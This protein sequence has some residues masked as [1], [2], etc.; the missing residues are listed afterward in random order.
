MNN[1]L[2]F[3]LFLC[4][5]S[6]ILL[7]G[8]RDLGCKTNMFAIKKESDNTTW[9][10][11]YHPELCDIQIP[12]V[13]VSADLDQIL[14]HP[15]DQYKRDRDKISGINRF[16][17]LEMLRRGT[18]KREELNNQRRKLV[19][20]Q[21]RQQRIDRENLSKTLQLRT[22]NLPSIQYRA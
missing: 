11:S 7:H 4:D 22:R 10:S 19:E 5:A 2:D 15:I 6:V 21:T 16:Y 12:W 9:Y 20:E 18:K 1:P 8:L 3:E 14:L 13:A 17:I